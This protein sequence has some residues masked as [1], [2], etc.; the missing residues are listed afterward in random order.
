MYNSFLHGCVDVEIFKGHSSSTSVFF[1]IAADSGVGKSTIYSHLVAPFRDLEQK[2]R[3]SHEE[4]LVKYKA[5][6]EVADIQSK[7]IKQRIAEAAKKGNNEELINCQSDL[8]KLSKELVEPKCIDV[9]A[10]DVTPEA[11]SQKLSDGNGILSLHS[12]EGGSIADGR[13]M[14]N[15]ALLCKAWSGETITVDRKTQERINVENPRLTI[16]IMS[17]YSVLKKL[18]KKK[19][20]SLVDIGF[21]PRCIFVFVEN[22]QGER[23]H[24]NFNI[25]E[26]M[27]YIAYLQRAIELLGELESYIIKTNKERVLVKFTPEARR[28]LDGIRQNIE[29]TLAPGGKYEYARGHGAKLLENIGRNAAVLSQFELGIGA[30]ISLGILQDA[31]R[32]VLYSSDQYL[33][34]FQVYPDYIKVAIA[35]SDHLSSL[36]QDGHRFAR[37]SALHRSSL[38]IF[39][40][41]DL[42]NKALD[43]L[44]EINEI[45]IYCLQSGLVYLDLYPFHPEDQVMWNKFCSENNIF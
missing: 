34:Y 26:D 43:H 12:P 40:D 10:D 8:I 18:V 42:F 44:V 3:K 5:A 39:R 7:I 32:I 29:P 20:E 33:Q 38:R 11:L 23:E 31:E 45:R 13:L 36:R 2:L 4:E 16:L 37:K 19:G 35:L 22:N 1:Y 24:R 15:L 14:N 6:K 27:S 28:Y 17:Q 25:Q 21:F 41:L 9:I 30:E